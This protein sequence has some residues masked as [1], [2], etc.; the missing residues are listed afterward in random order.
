MESRPLPTP[1]TT[2]ENLLSIFIF[3]FKVKL[4]LGTCGT[5]TSVSSPLALGI[6]PPC[7]SHLLHSGD[8]SWPRNRHSWG[9]AEH[10]LCWPSNSP[11]TDGNYS[12]VINAMKGMQ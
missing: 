10:V 1:V 8:Q 7:S 3:F 5:E 11:S 9:T 6:Q 12:S 4:E 2:L